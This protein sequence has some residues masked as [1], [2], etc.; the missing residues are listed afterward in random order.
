MEDKEKMLD[1]YFREMYLNGTILESTFDNNDIPVDCNS[2][3]N[4]IPKN[5][6]A[7]CMNLFVHSFILTQTILWAT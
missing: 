2:K 7:R 5:N 1:I 3:G 4:D 6:D